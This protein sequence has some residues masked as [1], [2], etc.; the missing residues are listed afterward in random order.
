VGTTVSSTG[1]L[2]VSVVGALKYHTPVAM[3]MAAITTVQNFMVSL[4]LKG[5]LSKAV[6]QLMNTFT[7]IGIFY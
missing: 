6:L 2:V 4:L 7:K 1:I 3:M 5:S